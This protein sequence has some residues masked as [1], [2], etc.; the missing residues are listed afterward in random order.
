MCIIPTNIY[1]PPYNFSLTDSHVIPG[2]IHKCYLAKQ[3]GEDF[4]VYG[5]GCSLRQFIYSQDL[6][7]LI[8]W[9]LKNEKI[10]E[11]LILSPNP[12]DEISIGEIA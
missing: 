4:I 5:T 10:N 11:S 9:I 12:Q 7:K 2:L 3:N 8:V 1:G 6:A